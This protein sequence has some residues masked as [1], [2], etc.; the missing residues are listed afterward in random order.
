MIRPINLPRTCRLLPRPSFHLTH[1]LLSIT[2]DFVHKLLRLGAGFLHI[3]DV[4]PG[5]G[6]G[7]RL[8]DATPCRCGARFARVGFCSCAVFFGRDG[9]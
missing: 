5:G 2:R 8:A 3:L 7:F 1:Q 9:V 4:C 6:S